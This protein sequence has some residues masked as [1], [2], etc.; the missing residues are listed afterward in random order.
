M[1]PGQVSPQETAAV[2]VMTAIDHP[3]TRS[4]ETEDTI[5]EVMIPGC[6]P[7]GETATH[8]AFAL[9]K[10]GTTKSP[11]IMGRTS[12]NHAFEVRGTFHPR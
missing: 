12:P 8:R 7:Y 1:I 5:R 2:I 11:P 4:S 6:V 10:Q 9:Q 3:T